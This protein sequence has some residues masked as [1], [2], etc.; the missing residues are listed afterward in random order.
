MA[1]IP[2]KCRLL[3]HEVAHCTEGAENLQAQT[4]LELR[5]P[6]PEI[7]WEAFECMALKLNALG[8]AEETDADSGLRT[9][10]A[11]FKP[12][13]DSASQYA[14]IRAA[15][16]EL[17]AHPEKFDLKLLTDDWETA[18]QHDWQGK[19]I[20]NC[21]WIRPSFREPATDGRIDI[22]LDPGMAFGTGQHATTSLCLRAIERA[23]TDK[24]PE[25]MLDMGAG[26][27]LL[28]IAAGKLGVPHIVAIDM[29]P[30]SV[31]AAKTNAGIN[32]ISIDIRLGDRPPNEAF[33]LV[34]ANILASPLINMAPKLSKCTM[35]RLVLSGLLQD[36][37]VEVVDTYVACGL[38][39]VK[40][41]TEDEWASVELIR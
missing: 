1:E 9:Y 28:A 18:W 10:V 19:A 23:C 2:A 8:S 41:S 27:G 30:D 34:V 22:V 12:D 35:N 40:V 14:S 5:L 26:S 29:D 15:L 11:W 4:C 13:S 32:G 37:V 3:F 36:Q 38:R 31:R 6:T 25:S 20:G 7:A 16:S 24:V 17:G 21:L 33:D 39:V